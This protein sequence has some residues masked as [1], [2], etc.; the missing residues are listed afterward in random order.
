MVKCEICLTK[1]AI[2][3]F[4]GEKKGRF[5]SVHKHSNMVNV[6]NKHCEFDGCIGKR[7]MYN[8]F[9]EKPKYCSLHY[10]NGMINLCG[11]KC[12]GSN[13]LKCYSIPIYNYIGETIGLYCVEHKLDNMVNITGKRCENNGCNV[14]AQYNY[15]G[16]VGGRFCSLHKLEN[17]VDVK[18]SRCE[19]D[20]CNISPSYKFENDSHCRF[21]SN[22]KLEGMVDGK[23]KKCQ[24]T[25]CYKSPSYNYDGEDKPVYCV[26][27]KM[28]EMID[29][30]HYRCEY[31]N[32]NLRPLYN[33]H[34]EK[35]GRFCMSHRYNEMVDVVSKKCLSEWCDINICTKKYE[36]YC[37]FC[38]IHLFPDKQVS[39]NYKTKERTVVEFILKIFSDF[40]WITDK[41]I[42]D[43]CSKRR[44]DLLLDLGYQVV[45]VEI[46]EN[47][48]NN[49]DC[50]CENKRLME[51]SKDIGHRPLIFIRFNPDSYINKN[52]EIIKSCWKANKNG[53]YIINKESNIDWN[54]RLDTLKNQIMYWTTNVCDKTIE[55]IHLY[56]DNF[57]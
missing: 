36:G 41:K 17:M 40:T 4:L 5:C 16:K 22:H 55:I 30:K 12:K 33:F 43:G 51:I 27:H 3:N 56:Y 52:N 6:V 34:K 18:H 10:S 53:I 31:G 38:F 50:I 8:F 21:C 25:G 13:G 7:A 2:F 35:K 46:D 47:Q 20:G 11:K 39:R 54:N 32:C 57:E 49:Y 24:E 37:L 28:D 26:E 48:H 14:I 9:G 42:Q 15:E 23:H 19:Y 45:I 29:V 44:P 1:T